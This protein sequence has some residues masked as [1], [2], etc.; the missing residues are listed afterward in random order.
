MRFLLCLLGFVL[1][2]IIS[3]SDT[4]TGR[5]L[6]SIECLLVEVVIE[7]LDLVSDPT[8]FCSDYLHI[9]TS[10]ITVSTTSTATASITTTVTTGTTIVS[11]TITQ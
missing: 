3:A 9:P 10:T 8:Q 6:E 2:A 5:N 4:N 7:V 11:S 1:P